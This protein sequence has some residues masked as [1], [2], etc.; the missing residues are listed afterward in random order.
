MS[1]IRDVLHLVFPDSCACCSAQ[2]RRGEAEI[3][4]SCLSDIEPTEFHVHPGDNEL[5]RRFAGKVPVEA[6]ASLFWFDK[7]GKLQRAISQMKYHHRPSIGRFMGLHYGRELAGLEWV[8]RCEAFIP[9]PLHAA[10]RAQRGFNQAEAFA[11]GLSR[12]TGIP[13]HSRA[14]RRTAAT[15]TQTRKSATERWE[16][17]KDVFTLDKPVGNSVI[18]VDDVITTGA[19]L[20]ACVRAMRESSFAPQWIGVLSIACTRRN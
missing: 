5:F 10:R 19:T 20:E 15:A 13:V 12:A 3:C 9:V 2:L 18:L 6:A 4:V 7:S 1:V 16:N 11:K 14:L 8:R 17:V